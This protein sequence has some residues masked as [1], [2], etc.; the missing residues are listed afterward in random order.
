MGSNIATETELKLTIRAGDVPA[1][2]RAL[3][4]RAAN[5]TGLSRA[6]LVSTY[7]DTADRALAR[8]GLT[9]RVRERDGKFVQTVKSTSR[10]GASG[11]ARGEWEDAIAGAEPD[12]EA[13]ETGGFLA[14][15]ITGRLTPLFRTEID[16]H[17]IDLALAP[18]AC[19]E[20]AIDRG[21]VYAPA[22][23]AEEP[24][25]E[26]ELELKSGPP[27]ALYDVMLRWH[28]SPS[29]RCGWSG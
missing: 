4:D 25:S 7:F 26:L 6:G 20:A 16:R 3:A 22:R 29:R 5:G 17:T 15:D 12:T 27:S 21:R 18:D 24:V 8:R 11:L 1:L 23:D 9:L 28:C 13:P 19:I 10:D 2:T 14:P